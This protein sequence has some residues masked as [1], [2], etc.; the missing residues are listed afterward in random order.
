LLLLA[1]TDEEHYPLNVDE[2]IPVRVEMSGE[3][4]TNF[5]TNRKRS[6]SHSYDWVNFA[7]GE[8]PAALFNVPAN[9]KPGLPS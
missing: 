4:S 5:P 7:A 6:I 2:R 3:G 8:P 1:C 9:C